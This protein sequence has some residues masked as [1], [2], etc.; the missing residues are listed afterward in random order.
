MEGRRPLL[1]VV[2]VLLASLAA[3][4]S[5]AAWRS[6]TSSKPASPP[7]PPAP[8]PPPP[9]ASASAQRA[10]APDA[11]VPPWCLARAVSSSL[12]LVSLHDCPAVPAILLL[13]Y[14][15][16]PVHVS[17]KCPS[18]WVRRVVAGAT[19]FARARAARVHPTQLHQRAPLL[20]AQYSVYTGR[21]ESELKAKLAEKEVSWCGWEAV[22]DG[23]ACGLQ[24]SPFTRTFV[25]VKGVRG[26]STS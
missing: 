20:R 15:W 7:P 4:P 9:P 17:V 3:P 19:G 11:P 14:L 1:A 12:D 16:T 26:A 22:L 5:V 25:G 23:T 2:A 6:S 18:S 13:P 24:V 10:A 21:T 8:P